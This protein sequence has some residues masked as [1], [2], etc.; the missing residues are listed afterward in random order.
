M[1]VNSI[2]DIVRCASLASFLE[3]AGWPKPGNVHRTKN[4]KNT[5]YEHFLAGIVAIQ[6]NFKEF[7]NRTYKYSINIG[8]D[9]SFVRLGYFFREAA[10]EMLKWQKGGNVLLGHILILAPLV[11]AAAICLKSKKIKYNNYILNIKKIINDSTVKDAQELYQAIKIVNPGGLGKV[12][13]YDINDE[14]SA[15]ILKRD[16]ITLKKI[17]ELSKNIDLISSEYSTD[18]N[19]ILN[20]GL[21]YYF[22]IFNQTNDINIA[23]VNTYLK[24]LSEHPDTLVIRK[25]G[26]EAAIMISNRAKEIITMGGIMT[27]KGLKLTQELDD[28]L[29]EKKGKMNPGTTAD[30]VAGI[31]FCALLFGLKF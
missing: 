10:K 1:A 12:D 13:K 31:I 18:F 16:G 17:F 8:E 9:F 30:I 14:N 26:I 2:D 21:P 6:P 7:C 20:E 15:I 28:F 24:V 23:T 27:E 19:I 25:S 11:A 29:H 5:R 4:F 22:E 3:L